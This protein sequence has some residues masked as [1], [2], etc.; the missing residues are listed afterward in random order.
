MGYTMKKLLIFLAVLCGAVAIF[1]LESA[2]DAERSPSGLAES[3]NTIVE[4]TDDGENL[5]CVRDAIRAALQSSSGGEVLD[6]VAKRVWPSRC[7]FVGHVVGQELFRKHNG[8][9]EPALAECSLTCDSPCQHGVIGEAYVQAFGVEA[10]DFDPAHLNPNDIRTFGKRLCTSS[11]VCHGIGHGLFQTYE[12]FEPALAMCEEVATGRPLFLCY[13]GVFMEYTDIMTSVNVWSS[14]I[15]LPSVADLDDVCAVGTEFQSR[16]CFRYF[17]RVVAKV[18]ENSGESESEIPRRLQ[19]TCESLN[20]VEERTACAAGVGVF[21]S[22]HTINEPALL[23][24]YCA[25]FSALKHTAACTYGA[26]STAVEYD[27]ENSFAYCSRLTESNLAAVCYQSIFNYLDAGGATAAAEDA[28]VGD[29]ACARGL[30]ARSVDSWEYL[31]GL[32]Y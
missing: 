10:E 19:E 26:I 20:S 31:S 3:S 8:A 5:E 29:E 2:R 16:T 9:I 4:C 12:S 21:F 13:R 18:Y 22:H 32:V 7:H 30:A 1:L 14:S 17:P 27:V 23:R 25:M 6:A 11:N 28:C 15:L 24:G